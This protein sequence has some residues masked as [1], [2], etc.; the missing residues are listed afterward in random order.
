MTEADSILTTRSDALQAMAQEL[1][2]GNIAVP[3][4]LQPYPH[5]SDLPNYDMPQTVLPNVGTFS[6]VTSLQ[7]DT[8][9]CC[10]G[11]PSHPG[12]ELHNAERASCG[13]QYWYTCGFFR[14]EQRLSL[15]ETVSR[16]QI[17][18]EHKRLHAYEWIRLS[19]GTGLSTLAGSNSGRRCIPLSFEEGSCGDH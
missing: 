8:H 11:G 15:G 4:R 12:P 2:N 6:K 3:H 14:T 13:G 9:Q 16:E 7:A 10:D 5:S 19:E 1:D 18:Q 17:A